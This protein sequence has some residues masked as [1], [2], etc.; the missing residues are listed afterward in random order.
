MGDAVETNFVRN[1]S[2]VV[3]RAASKTWLAPAVFDSAIL[4]ESLETTP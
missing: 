3:I 1:F 2:D 4:L